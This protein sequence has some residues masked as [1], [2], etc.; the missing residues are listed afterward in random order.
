MAT[1][2]VSNQSPRQL[3]PL[4]NLASLRIFIFLRRALRLSN[5]QSLDLPQVRARLVL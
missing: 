4:R 5:F 3:S 2:I 1:R